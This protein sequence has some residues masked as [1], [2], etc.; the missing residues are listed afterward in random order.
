[1][2]VCTYTVRLYIYNIYIYMYRCIIYVQSCVFTRPSGSSVGQWS[3]GIWID[4][5]RIAM[6]SPEELASADYD[7]WKSMKNIT[8]KTLTHKTKN[9]QKLYT[10]MFIYVHGAQMF[11]KNIQ[12][13]PTHVTMPMPSGCRRSSLL[14]LDPQNFSPA[15]PLAVMSLWDF[16]WILN[17]IM[18]AYE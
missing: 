15:L 7:I 16:L 5:L 9:I 17:G 1:M 8:K 12:K 6:R 18:Y 3:P 13:K 4:L 2:C 14:L 10:H 11:S